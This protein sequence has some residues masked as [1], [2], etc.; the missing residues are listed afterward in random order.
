M[1]TVNIARSGTPLKTAEVFQYYPN[2]F[3]PET[4]I[5]YTLFET[6]NVK[7]SIFMQSDKLIRELGIKKS[8]F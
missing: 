7:F 5:P 4:W 3:N 1:Q 8:L 2:L 6:S